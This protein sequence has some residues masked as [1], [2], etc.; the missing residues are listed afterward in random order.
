MA[1][2]RP[3]RFGLGFN[4]PH[5]VPPTPPTT[6][7]LAADQR[8]AAADQRAAA[9]DQ[10]AQKAMDKLAVLEGAIF[11]QFAGDAGAMTAEGYLYAASSERSE[12]AKTLTKMKHKF[13]DLHDEHLSLQRRNTE[14]LRQTK[15]ALGERRS[16]RRHRPATELEVEGAKVIRANQEIM[17]LRLENNTLKGQ[18]L[19]SRNQ[20]KVRDSTIADRDRS[21]AATQRKNRQLLWRRWD[22]TVPADRVKKVR[23]VDAV[24]DVLLDKC[25]GHPDNAADVIS[26]VVC[27]GRV[28]SKGDERTDALAL[29][30]MSPQRRADIVFKDHLATRIQRAY[31]IVKA[32]RSSNEMKVQRP[33]GNQVSWDG[34]GFRHSVSQVGLL[35]KGAVLNS[36]S[37]R[38]NWH[39]L[40]G[41]R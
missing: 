34:V 35:C 33:F 29:K 12:S 25:E 1:G 26:G 17:R 11:S 13:D 9:A 10:R 40:D 3:R 15:P 24:Q 23:A 8:V 41:Q 16:S 4:T 20:V 36:G 39:D 14:L 22:S 28:F 38:C 2:G 27:R 7:L 30:I 31:R 37:R 6:A 19:T 18:L 21:I 32:R 5:L